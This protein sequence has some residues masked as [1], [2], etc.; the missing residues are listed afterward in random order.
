MVEAVLPVES[1]QTESGAVMV[2]SG[3]ALT[4]TTFW[5][6]SEQPLASVTVTWRVTSAVLPA[7]G[8]QV[9]E[10]VPEPAVIEPL[11]IVQL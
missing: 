9:M 1:S 5:Q 3:R 4:V 2:Q 6:V 10:F 7:S 11:V 8:S